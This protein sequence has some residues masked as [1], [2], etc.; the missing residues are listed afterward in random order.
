MNIITVIPLTRSKFVDTLTYFTATEVPVGAIVSVPLRSKTIFAIVTESKPGQDMKS[1]IKNST[2]AIRKLGKVNASMFFPASFM[3]SCRLLADYYATSIGAI[4]DTLISDT[5][6]ENASD[7]APPLPAQTAFISLPTS[8]DETYAVQGDDTDRVSSWRSLIR[9]EFARKKSISIYAPTV[10][11]AKSAFASLEKGIEG[12][13]FL[14]HGGLPKKKIIETW[15]AVANTE[16]PIVVVATGSFSLIPRSDIDTVIIERE[17]GRGWISQKQPYMDVRHALETIARRRRQTVYLAD[18]LLRTETLRRVDEHEIAEGSPF[19]WRSVS[20]A[21]DILV[22]MKKSVT[23]S[24]S[25]S[26]SVAPASQEPLQTNLNAR[27]ANGSPGEVPAPHA[28]IL[29]AASTSPAVSSFSP[30]SDTRAA[31]APFRIFSP[32]LEELIRLNQEEN[33]HLFI[34]AVR[35]GHSPT[36]VCS[37]CETIVTCRNCSAPVVLHASAG[38]GRNFFMCHKCGE[39]RSANETCITC[40]SWN[41]VALGIG[42]ERVQQEIAALFPGA[43]VFR[44]DADTTK[45]DKQIKDTMERFRNKPG[46]ILVGTEMAMLHLADKVEH[47]AVA[48]LDSLFALPD[49]RIQ[50]KIMYTLIRLRALAARSI[51]VQT[52]CFDEKIFE[53]AL[54][55]NLSDFHRSTLQERKR[56]AYPPFSRLIKITIEGKKDDIATSM[57]AIQKLAEPRELD[58]FPA[59]TS[60]VRN[61]SVIHGLIKVEPGQW[62]DVEL[63]A[64]LRSLPPNV[65]VKINPESLL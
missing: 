17:N 5:L 37:D 65:S 6:L 39:R 35:R 53:W 15:T 4:I 51:L 48:S 22:D 41:L 3:E 29:T 25:L 60:T 2:Y 32:E 26:D 1:D 18:S 9:Q 55:G 28:A 21:R 27:S 11:D 23:A 42:I 34:L 24:R 36:T 45:T 50:E 46:S 64:K 44:I 63:V 8:T 47:I 58:I 10:E 54:K 33:T 13:I 49:F 19:K 57:A 59:F 52:R 12:Y 40:G 16:H 7:I 30:E 62:P 14:L 56:F 31:P 43:D 38:T 61:N 20:T